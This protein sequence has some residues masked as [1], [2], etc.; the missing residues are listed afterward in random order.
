MKS[1]SITLEQLIP[2]N[3]LQ[4]VLRRF[5]ASIELGYRILDVNGEIVFETDGD[6]ARQ[7]EQISHF[8]RLSPTRLDIGQLLESWS[9]SPVE[10]SL[11]TDANGSS[12]IGAPLFAEEVLIAI[13]CIGPFV[14]TSGDAEQV[15]RRIN[16]AGE[17][18]WES[19]GVSVGSLPMLSGKRIAELTER[20]AIMAE[21]M[22]EMVRAALLERKAVKQLQKSEER[23]RGMIN[24]LP[25]VIYETDLKGTIIFANQAAFDTFGYSP[26]EAGIEGTAHISE[27][28][29]P[30]DK[31]K[32]AQRFKAVLSGSTLAPEEYWFVR[33]NGEAFPGV[34]ISRAILKDGVVVGVRGV[35]I[36]NRSRWHVEE[37]LKESEQRYRTLYNGANDG[38]LILENGIIV[39]CNPRAQDLLQRGPQ[40]LIGSTLFN[41]SP[42]LQS[43]GQ[44]S[45]FKAGK[46]FVVDGQEASGCFSWDFHLRDGTAIETE[47]SLNSIT[48]EGKTLGLAIFRD[49][50]ERNQSRRALEEQESAWR[51]IFEHAP[52][53]IVI[54]R[55][56]DGVYLDAN[57][58]YERY[59]GGRK[60][61]DIL[62]KT[63]EDFLTPEQ[64][65]QSQ[66]VREVLLAKGSIYDQEAIAVAPDGTI[67]HLLYS[68]ALYQTG[69]EVNALSMFVDITDRKKTEEQLKRNEEVLNSLFQAVPVGLA[70]L[71][72]RRFTMI[73]EQVG[74]IT[75]HLADDLIGST[76]RLLYATEEEYIRVGEALYGTLWE[77]G[78][79][80][81]ETRFKH[82]NGSF[83]YVSLFAAPLDNHNSDAGAAVAIQDITE[84]VMMVQTLRDREQRFLKIA[85]LSGQLLYDHDVSSGSILWFGRIHAITGYSAE[86]FNTHGISGWG[87]RLHPDDRAITLAQLEA[88][89]VNRTVF[90][91]DYR[92]CK[93]DQTYIHVH[94]EGAY[95]YDDKGDA[96]Q[97][98]GT[99]KDV[100][101]QKVAEDALRLSERRLA[102]A[103]SATSDAIWEWY[104]QDKSTYYS[105]RW[106]EMLGYED[107]ELAMTVESWVTLCHPDDYQ[108]VV[109]NIERAFASHAHPQYAIEYRMRHY[110]GH[111]LW[112]L[113]RG[114]V[115]EWDQAN[116]PS[117]VTGTNTDIT[118]RKQAEI[119]LQ[120][121]EKR[122][123]ALFESGGDAIF[124]L[125]DDRVI[126]CNNKTLELFRCT[127]DQFIGLSP[128]Q[129][130]PPVQA[131]GRIFAEHGKGYIDKALL[132]DP[133]Q[134]EWVHARTDGTQFH[135][136]VRLGLIELSGET[137]VQAIIRDI[138]E[139]KKNE[140]AL[141]ESEFRFRSFFNTSPEGI[142]LID[143]QGNILDANKTFQQESGYGQDE[144]I[145]QHFKKFI[146]A[147]DQA[148]IV[149]AI[150]AF[151]SGIAQDQP[152][153]FSYRA[154]N[155]TLVP[156]LAKGWLVVD[157]KSNPLYLGVFIHNLST[158]LALADEKAALEKQVIQAQR[159]EAIGTLAGGIAHDFN[160]IL[161]G[162]IGYT[163]L[164][165]LRAETS[166]DVKI[167]DYIQRVLE[168]GNRAKNLVQQI[169][170][171]SRHTA[172]IMEPIHLTPV[173]NESIA[174]MRSTLPTTIT[175]KHQLEQVPDRILGDSTQIHQVVMNLATNALHAMKDS[176]GLLTITLK[177]VFLDVP[178]QFL[179]MAIPAGEYMLLQV[180]DTGCGMP[181]AVLERIFEPYFTT[182]KINEGTGLGMAV[183]LGIIKS[184]KGLIEVESIIGTG[185][186]FDIYLPLTREDSEQNGKTTSSLPM[187]RGEHVLLVDDEPFFLEVV[188]ENLQLLGYH[189]TANLSSLDALR[190]Y[191]STPHDYDLLITDQTM[192]EMTGVQ[193][194]REIRKI[195]KNLPIILC[196]GYSEIVSE[197]S[198]VYYGINQFLMKPVNTSDLAQAVAAVLHLT[199]S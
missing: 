192:P 153:R 185:T 35:V 196:T 82:K 189:V 7:Q 9:A 72:D 174:L 102:H 86:E 10:A 161:G 111:W 73:N 157:E 4:S 12:S 96:V 49:M 94:E 129:F 126:D 83:R 115:V 120:E 98:L 85:D 61:S 199:N 147:E 195:D 162:I 88:A 121:S 125:K 15:S 19:E 119:A 105:S 136:D 148:R 17:H 169:L 178:R 116:R 59:S 11:L 159:S 184:H 67:R 168:G 128:E 131:D 16:L 32:V 163:E 144:I 99:V 80:Y 166:M 182:K 66:K 38:I 45:A 104:P 60:R 55:L 78:A 109:Q 77:R 103:F 25:Q 79:S 63:A 110:Q 191:T 106:Y 173:I 56:S 92:F 117:L 57:P 156:V 137:C 6:Q 71:K 44:L 181:V 187:G 20:L 188:Q 154:E 21:F 172:T 146:Q 18:G 143:F 40:D 113:S 127:R 155:G 23:Y 152:I 27:F 28:I 132:D 186:R 26:D 95:L 112:I 13:I 124:I 145:H 58:A 165:L 36:D 123:R 100:T 90:S 142:L 54:N 177:K 87:E 160:N 2:L 53:G 24:S 70:I 190:L 39:E 76:S 114:R 22:A 149:E 42:P 101:C 3:R 134:F 89:K 175:I 74:T 50:T 8:A 1:P 176:G 194:V 183:V 43:D 48:M 47:V 151:K 64:I 150:L 37:K 107:H 179:S 46:M 180:E 193:L 135:A 97:M 158:E 41:V 141:R 118:K 122:Y 171:F 140:S 197:Q 68:S 31:D 34:V 108:A 30:Q 167:R 138:T 130:S 133:Q 69:G 198:A 164:A 75:G 170:R 81:V 65:E 33:K 14:C 91:V 52:Y 62:G 93:A 139:W 29:S 84:R 5:S 51:A